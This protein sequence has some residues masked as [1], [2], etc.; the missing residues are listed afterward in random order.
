MKLNTPYYLARIDD[1]KAN[2]EALKEAIS[3]YYPNYKLAYSF[4]TNYASGFI[5]IAKEIGLLAE[6]VS[7]KELALAVK[8]G[9]DLKDII[10][11]GLLPDIVGKYAVINGGGTVVF[12]N[13][14]ELNEVYKEWVKL[15]KE[16]MPIGVRFNIDLN[17]GVY[18]R[19][20]IKP[21]SREYDELLSRISRNFKVKC[22]HCHVS[23]AR[24]LK[25]FGNRVRIM[26][27]IAKDF[28]APIID[29]GGN[30]YGPMDDSFKEQY[31]TYIPTFEDYGRMIGSTMKEMFPDEERIL[32]TEN[33]TAIVGNAMDLYASVVKKSVVGMRN[34]ITL[35]CKYSDVGFSCNN[36][37][38]SIQTINNDSDYIEHAIVYG[39][40]CLERDVIHRDFSGNVDVGDIVVI[41][42]VGAYSLNVTNIF[43]SDTPNVKYL[44]NK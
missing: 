5:K 23:Y 39:C 18:S 6:V 25:S 10:Y 40:T 2:S 27:D 16:R 32:I 20:G 24:D 21:H 13:I 9:Y 36:K 42:N 43:I 19:F 1:F 28:N 30:M 26:A 17:N 37:N 29:I 34:A 35:D 4:K 31:E 22:V 33:G 7:N 3:N 38:P 14:K 41:K 8:L 11:N 15:H 44:K 12:D